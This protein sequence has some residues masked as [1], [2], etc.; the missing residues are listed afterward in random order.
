VAF[1]EFKELPEG[2]EIEQTIVQNRSDL[3]NKRLLVKE[4]T[5]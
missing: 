4:L 5:D 3:K 1:L 2:K